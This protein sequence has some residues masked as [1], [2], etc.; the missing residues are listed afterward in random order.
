MQY[1]IAFFFSYKSWKS[2]MYFV[3]IPHLSFWTS[4]IWSADSHMY[5][6]ATVLDSR[7]LDIKNLSLWG[8]KIDPEVWRC[9]FLITLTCYLCWYTLQNFWRK[10]IPFTTKF[11][12]DGFEKQLV[13]WGHT[14][15]CVGRACGPSGAVLW[16]MTIQWGRR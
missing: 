12:N 4:H 2:D 5:I 7:A 3:L 15:Y 10:I 11:K 14:V 16:K 1:F 13:V 6:V 8:R 9:I